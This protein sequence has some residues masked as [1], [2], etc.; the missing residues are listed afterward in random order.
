MKKELGEPDSMTKG[1]KGIRVIDN[2]GNNL[3]DLHTMRQAFHVYQ[4]QRDA[5]AVA[6]GHQTK[7]RRPGCSARPYVKDNV[8]KNVK[9]EAR[10]VR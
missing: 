4:E 8:K 5:W 2:E 9:K 6:T 1:W 3:G 7:T 10:E